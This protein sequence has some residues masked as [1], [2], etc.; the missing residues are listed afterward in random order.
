MKTIFKSA[1][2]ACIALTAGLAGCSKEAPANDNQ[3]ATGEKSVVIKIAGEATRAPGAKE[4]GTAIFTTADIYFTNGTAVMNK[5]T[6][7][8]ALLTGADGQEFENISGTVTDVYIIGNRPAGVGDAFTNMTQFDA[9]TLITLANQSDIQN[10]T[11]W[12]TSPVTTLDTPDADPTTGNAQYTV[13]VELT[14]LVAR[15]EIDN[16]E[17]RKPATTGEAEITSFTLDGIYLDGVYTEMGFTFA[18]GTLFAGGGDG[19]TYPGTHPAQVMDDALTTF[20]NGRTYTPVVTV[21]GAD[22]DG[23]WAYNLLPATGAKLPTIVLKL[24][25]I[26]VAGEDTADPVFPG[27]N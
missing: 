14:P 10:V 2:V 15:F 12:G 22:E 20:I 3:P 18:A 11:L 27:A 9:N 1:L 16:I 19:D 17:A 13:D 5:F 6:G 8:V 21:K 24:S 23:V 25:D 7:N 4:T 26:V